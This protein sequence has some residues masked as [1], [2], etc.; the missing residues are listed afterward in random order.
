MEEITPQRE[1]A[2][3]MRESDKEKRREEEK[4]I[5]EPNEIVDAGKYIV[6][7]NLKLLLKNHG[8]T[9]KLVTV[10]FTSDGQSTRKEIVTELANEY[11]KC[12][13]SRQ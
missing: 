4:G 9:T 2:E 5:T 10:D 11:V 13:L 1:V 7:F 12:H 8:H 6:S 3:T